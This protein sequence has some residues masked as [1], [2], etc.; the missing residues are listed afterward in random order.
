VD[1]LRPTLEGPILDT[2]REGGPSL[3]TVEPEVMLVSASLERE[4]N[5]GRESDAKADELPPAED[6]PATVVLSCL[7]DNGPLFSLEGAPRPMIEEFAWFLD[8][9]DL[10]GELSDSSPRGERR[11]VD[12]PARIRLFFHSGMADGPA[13]IVGPKRFPAVLVGED[14]GLGS[15]LATALLLGKEMGTG[16]GRPAG[17]LSLSSS[18]QLSDPD[19]PA[20]AGLASLAELKVSASRAIERSSSRPLPASSFQRA[21]FFGVRPLT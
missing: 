1:T 21:V 8:G 15:P 13:E 6:G 18:I 3:F 2:R 16:L 20:S 12:L 5:V 19:S 14:F 9:A 10:S 11:V 17:L 4:A 7:S